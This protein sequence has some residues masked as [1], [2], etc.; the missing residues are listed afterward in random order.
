MSLYGFFSIPYLLMINLCNIFNE[1]MAGGISE[2][3][4][5]LC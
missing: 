5:L 1:N 2:I 3:E 4:L